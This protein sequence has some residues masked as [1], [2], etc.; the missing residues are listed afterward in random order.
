M[1]R[2]AE[3]STYPHLQF[4]AWQVLTVLSA[5]STPRQSVNLVEHGVELAAVNI[6]A[7]FEREHPYVLDKAM[8]CL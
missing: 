4:E 1:L 3:S 2:F 6:T 7:S 5:D 8:E